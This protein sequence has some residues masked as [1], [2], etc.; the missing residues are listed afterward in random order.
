MD[1]IDGHQFNGIHN[2]ANCPKK[3]NY[4]CKGKKIIPTTQLIARSGP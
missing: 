2:I 3:E 1:H 4:G